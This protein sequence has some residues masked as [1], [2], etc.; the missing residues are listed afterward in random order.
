MVPFLI[1]KAPNVKQRVLKERT[2]K[3]ANRSA[4]KTRAKRSTP[5]QQEEVA[6]DEDACCYCDDAGK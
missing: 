4:R 3:P 6:A 1:E 5:Q 2:A